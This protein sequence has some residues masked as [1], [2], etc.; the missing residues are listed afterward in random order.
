MERMGY[1][2]RQ[3]DG[4]NFGKGR[5]IPLQ[6]FVPKG[7]PPNYYDRTR[8]GLGYVTPTEQSES[9]DGSLSPIQ[10]QSSS[11]SGWEYDVSVGAVFK[12]LSVNMTSASHIEEEDESQLEPLDCDP[13]AQQMS[14]QWEMRFEQREP[15][16]EDKV[17]QVDVGDKD[18]SKP[19]FISESL[20]PQ[21]REDHISLIREYIDV[22]AWS[23]EDMPGLDP[24]IAMHR[25]NIKPDAK[26]VKQQQRQ[27]RPDIME[28]IETEVNKLIE[29]GFIREEQHPD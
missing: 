8:R 5:R 26:P 4:L 3:G 22:F 16:T 1:N 2:L 13:W 6:P 9:E 10:S 12:N 18:H 23:Y 24:E 21:E 27:F 14:Y 7:K 17:I 25:L 29:C 28:A 19:I 15:P 20:S 11:S